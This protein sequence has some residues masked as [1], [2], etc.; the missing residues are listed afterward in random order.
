MSRFLVEFCE[1]R[2]SHSS[3]FVFAFIFIFPEKEKVATLSQ[4]LTWSHFVVLLPIEDELERNF[5]AAMCKN[6]G[7]S[8]LT[9][10]E[11]RQSMLYQRTAISQ[12]PEETIRN[13]VAQLMDAD[14]MTLD[15]FYRDPYVLDLASNSTLKEISIITLKVT[16]FYAIMPLTK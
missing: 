2:I 7:R 8:V 15:L 6:E 13:D 5:Y 3:S 10:R 11:R 14:K 9:L 16:C 4:Q 12:K 1:K